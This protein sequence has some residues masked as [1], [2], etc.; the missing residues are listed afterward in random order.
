MAVGGA[1]REGD[2]TATAGGQLAH[3]QDISPRQPPGPTAT[4][5]TLTASTVGHEV[6]TEAAL[7]ARVARLHNPTTMAQ[8]E[9]LKTS[10]RNRTGYKGVSKQSKGSFRAQI[11]TGGVDIHVGCFTS[12]KRAAVAYAR[13]KTLLESL[14][15]LETVDALLETE[16]DTATTGPAGEPLGTEPTRGGGP[17]LPP[18]PP[19]HPSRWK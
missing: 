7:A 11:R 15:P 2:A 19:Q 1:G 9:Q 12:A 5:I 6:H 13:A 18:S 16:L 17:S 10:D 14:S 4:T 3:R 8:C